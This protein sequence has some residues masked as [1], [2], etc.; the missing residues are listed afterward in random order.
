MFSMVSHQ[1]SKSNWKNTHRVRISDKKM[2]SKL[3]YEG[4]DLSR[5]IIIEFLKNKQIL[6]YLDMKINKC[7][8]C[9]YQKT[10]I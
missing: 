4:V 5:K 9:T 6:I 2:V 3:D 7:I 1:T 10:I 8:H